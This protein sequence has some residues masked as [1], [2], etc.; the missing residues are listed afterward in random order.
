MFTFVS[1][2]TGYQYQWASNV[3]TKTL[4]YCIRG[5]YDV[6]FRKTIFFHNRARFKK[7][8]YRGKVVDLIPEEDGNKLGNNLLVNNNGW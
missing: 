4:Y 1:T 3:W 7:L 8:Q 2:S 5:R 6:F